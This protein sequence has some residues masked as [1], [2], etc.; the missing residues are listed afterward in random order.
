[1]VGNGTFRFLRQATLGM[2]DEDIRQIPIDT[3]TLHI[4]KHVNDVYSG[5]VTDGHKQVH[6]F[7]NKSLPA[8]SAE[9]M[10]VF[11]WYSPEDEKNVEVLEESLLPD[12]KI[13]LNLNN[14]IDHYKKHNIS[15]IYSEMENIRGEIRNGTAVDLQ[16]VE[17]RIMK[18]FDKLEETL[19]NNANKHNELARDAGS[20]IDELEAKMRELQAKVEEMNLRPTSINAFSTN[21][22]DEKEIYNNHYAYLPKPEV[23]IS[24]DGRIK[25]SFPANWTPLDRSN[26]LSDMKAKV[27]KTGKK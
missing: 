14:L 19:L 2:T 22:P 23:N 18:L 25:I 9:L 6:Q 16:Q 1:M 12:D 24:P 7:T 17:T 13:N 4:R 15:N 21:P 11:E 10:S 8:V 27:V 5:R 3:Y 26:F 20:A